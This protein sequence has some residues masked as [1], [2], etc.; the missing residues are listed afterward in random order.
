M[1]TTETIVGR[2]NDRMRILVSSGAFFHV[3]FL[4]AAAA[5]QVPPSGRAGVTSIDYSLLDRELT[6][7]GGKVEIAG[8]FQHVEFGLFSGSAIA[9]TIGYGIGSLL[10]VWGEP[11]VAVDPEAELGLNFGG[12]VRLIDGQEF[13]M[14]PS[15]AVKMNITGPGDTIPAMTMGLDSRIRLGSVASLFILHGLVN[16]SFAADTVI[17]LAN[18]G[19]GLHLAEIIGLRFETTPFGFETAGGETFHY[20]D[21]IPFGAELVLNVDSVDVFFSLSFPDLENA[22]DFYVLTLGAMGRF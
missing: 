17:I 8:R 18:I 11:V 10:E 19:L 16:P 14:A 2:Y 1:A 15:I 9:G 3:L 5:A 21:A 13:D 6:L 4:A 20:G 22:G 7:E 12:A